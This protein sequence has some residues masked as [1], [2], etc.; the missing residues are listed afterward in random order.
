MGCT[1]TDSQEPSPTLRAAVAADWRDGSPRQ[2]LALLAVGVWMAYEWG[3]GNETVTPWIL[4]RVLKDNEGLASVLATA[5]VGLVFTA[6]QQLVSGFTALLGFSMFRRS[7]AAAWRRL[8]SDGRQPPGDWNRLSWPGRAAIAF[9]LGTTA[10]A[11]TQQVTTGD[12]GVRRHGSEV[13]QSALL[14]GALVAALGAMAGGLAW[15]GRE[16]EA[17]QGGTDRVIDVLANP[18][19]W[20]SL[21][22]AVLLAGRLR[23]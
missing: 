21:A 9:G 3:P 14:C 12:V 23:R 19:V 18:L 7:S 15:L 16:V 1:L 8:S 6:V 4:L 11:L 10:V 13:V 5:L 2:R 17:L 20:L 22:A